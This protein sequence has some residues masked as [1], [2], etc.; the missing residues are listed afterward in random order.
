MPW[1][2]FLSVS[3]SHTIFF[4][5]PIVEHQRGIRLQAFSRSREP[6]GPE[7]LYSRLQNDIELTITKD[8]F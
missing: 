2:A 6:F 1:L 4:S 3:D 7:K 5:R 8:G